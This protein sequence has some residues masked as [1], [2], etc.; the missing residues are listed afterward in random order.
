MVQFPKIPGLAQLTGRIT[1]IPYPVRV[2]ALSVTT[3][4]ALIGLLAALFKRKRSKRY[5]K[6]IQK[7]GEYTRDKS[8]RISLPYSLNGGKLALAK[9]ILK[10]NDCCHPA[11]SFPST[12]KPVLSGHSQKDKKWVLKTYYCLM[13]V[14][15][16]TECSKGSILQ[17]F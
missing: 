14:K 16:I 15:S 12:V 9:A 5:E 2:T 10:K 4:L 3:T 8:G 1:Q 11:H 7:R 6:E 13:Q 17:Y